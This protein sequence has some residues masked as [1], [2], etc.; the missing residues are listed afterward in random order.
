MVFNGSSLVK[1]FNPFLIGRYFTNIAHHLLF[2]ITSSGHY[3]KQI[4]FLYSS[5]NITD[6]SSL[7]QIPQLFD[8]LINSDYDFFCGVIDVCVFVHGREQYNMDE[9]SGF[10]DMH[11]KLPAKQRT[12]F[13]DS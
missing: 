3:Y 1:S 11:K 4:Y 5:D 13:R 2:L 7:C 10:S 12:G 6:L 9:H 8:E